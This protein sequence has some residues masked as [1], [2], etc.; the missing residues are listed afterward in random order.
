V[1]EPA[2]QRALYDVIVN[3]GHPR[4]WGIRQRTVPPG[5]KVFAYLLQDVN[6]LPTVTS[7]AGVC[8]WDHRKTCEGKAQSQEDERNA[9]ATTTDLLNSLLASRRPIVF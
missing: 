1:G 8:D 3:H 4:F 9:D 2:A 7:V 5:T 6:G